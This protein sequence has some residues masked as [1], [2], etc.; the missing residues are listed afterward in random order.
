MITYYDYPEIEKIVTVR[1]I[2]LNDEC[3]GIGMSLKCIAYN[4]YNAFRLVKFNDDFT[5]AKCIAALNDYID[6]SNDARSEMGYDKYSTDNILILQEK[7]NHQYAIPFKYY[8][9]NNHVMFSGIYIK[10]DSSM[11]ELCG[12]SYPIGVHN[13]IE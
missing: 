5:K 12:H 4:G 1:G 7:N 10:G 13:R 6:K 8:A 11:S 9:N 3:C 2:N